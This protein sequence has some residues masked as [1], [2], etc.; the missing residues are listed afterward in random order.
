M[1]YEGPYESRVG[2][3]VS[4]RRCEKIR[5]GERFPVLCDLEVGRRGDEQ[6]HGGWVKVLLSWGGE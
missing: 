4:G 6:R 1:L 2:E 3:A 5:F